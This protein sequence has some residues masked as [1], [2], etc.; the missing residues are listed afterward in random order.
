MGE[1]ES[2]MFASRNGESRPTSTY[3]MTSPLHPLA[4][5]CNREVAGRGDRSI[6]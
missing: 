2:T 4:C 3:A 1:C 5:E 6:V